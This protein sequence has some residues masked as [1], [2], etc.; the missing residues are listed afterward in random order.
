[1]FPPL[2]F[3]LKFNIIEDLRLILDIWVPVVPAKTWEGALFVGV[4]EPSEVLQGSLWRTLESLRVRPPRPDKASPQHL[5][6]SWHFSPSDLLSER[7]LL[8]RHMHSR[9]FAIRPSGI[10]VISDLLLLRSRKLCGVAF[11]HFLKL[12]PWFFCS[13]Y[14]RQKRIFPR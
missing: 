7:Q 6:N 10:R 3:F 14:S 8:C 11:F 9:A 13:V 2:D 4:L 12:V 1:M 5:R